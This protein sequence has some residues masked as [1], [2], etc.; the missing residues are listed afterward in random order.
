MPANKLS[1]NGKWYATIFIVRF[2]KIKFAPDTSVFLLT[3]FDWCYFNAFDS[4]L[5]LQKHLLI[6]GQNLRESILLIILCKKTDLCTVFPVKT[7]EIEDG[8][9]FVVK[10]IGEG[11]L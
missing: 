5:L 1:H 10:C 4:G 9:I 8:K 7:G 3:I 2:N 6:Y 11:F